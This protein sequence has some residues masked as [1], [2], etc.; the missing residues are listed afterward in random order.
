MD[1]EATPR[2]VVQIT[3]EPGS[4]LFDVFTENCDPIQLWGMARLLEMMGNQQWAHMQAG[5]ARQMRA[6]MD[7]PEIEVAQSIPENLR[8]I[9]GKEPHS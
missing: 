3:A 1:K 2:T 8:S 4:S 6:G 5:I 7:A 9:F